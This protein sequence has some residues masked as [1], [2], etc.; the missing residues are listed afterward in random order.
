MPFTARPGNRKDSRPVQVNYDR[1]ASTYNRRFE[2]DVERP[3][4]ARALGQLAR[5]GPA[6]DVLEVGC[7]TGHW[8]AQLG[9]EGCQPTGL[10]LSIGMLIE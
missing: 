9:R 1:I 7:G 3:G 8:L 5:E 6:L 2:P 4:I 10:D